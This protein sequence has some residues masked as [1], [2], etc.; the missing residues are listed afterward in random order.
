MGGGGVGDSS[1]LSETSTCRIKNYN[2]PLHIIDTVKIFIVYPTYPRTHHTH[3]FH[4]LELLYI[5]HHRRLILIMY[6]TSSNTY[7][8]QYRIAEMSNKT[9]TPPSVSRKN[10][11]KKSPK[12]V[13]AGCPKCDAGCVACPKAMLDVCPNEAAW[14]NPTAL[15]IYRA[16]QP[17]RRRPSTGDTRRGGHTQG[18][19]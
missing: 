12:E 9:I 19:T 14:P 7:F 8:S 2:V 1:A 16:F 4:T 11:Q 10:K 17:R 6:F 5:L 13:G 18:R 15:C 3:F